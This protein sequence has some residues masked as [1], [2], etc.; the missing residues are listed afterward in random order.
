MKPQFIQIKGLNLAYYTKN[1]DQEHTIFFVHG[2]SISSAMWKKQFDDPVFDAYRLVAVD[3]P[4]H[5]QSDASLNPDRDYSLPGLASIVSETLQVLVGEYPYLLVGLSLGANMVAELLA[6]GVRP[7]GIALAGPSILGAS[8]PV[9]EV[10][11]PGTHVY[12]V[13][14]DEAPPAAIEA[15][16]QEGILSADPTDREAFVKDYNRVKP[17]FRSALNR[18][19]EE[20]VYSDEIRLLAE[21]GIPQ[22]VIMGAD[23]QVVYPD[24]LDDAGLPL[25]RKN[26]HK[27]P[28]ASH[29]VN[30]DRPVEFN[31]LLTAFAADMF[32]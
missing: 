13:F 20:E 22:C 19:L 16:A 3:L 6:F 31:R 32:R 9:S 7:K 15:Y 28:G 14:T 26:V 1:D 11:K 12:V 23:E 29:L 2:N 5:G 27:I 8:R 17:P 4:A 10:V 18:S 25:W 24:Y 21:S 30:V